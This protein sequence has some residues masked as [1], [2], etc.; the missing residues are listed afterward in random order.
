MLRRLALATSLVLGALAPTATAGPLDHHRCG[1]PAL[2]RQGPIPPLATHIPARAA[3]GGPKLTREG[4]GGSFQQH[5]STNFAIKWADPTV[6]IAQAQVV[7]D[8]LE[9]AWAKYV[10][11]LGHDPCTGC[12]TFR[13]NAYISRPDDYPG[14]DFGGGYAYIDDDGYP[15]FVISRSLFGGPETLEAIRGVAVHEFYHDIQF[16]TGA[17]QWGVTDYGW[18]WEA[19]AEWATQEALPTSANPYAFSGPFALKSELPLYHYGDPFGA[20]P[21]EG[22]HQ[23]GASIFFRYLTDKL[24]APGVIINTWEQASATDEPLAAVAAQLPSSDLVTIH[25]E[26]AARNA[27]WDYPYRQFI[28]E[29]IALYRGAYPGLSEIAGF[30]PPQGI[31][32]TALERSPYG[33]GYAT[34]ELRRPPTGRFRIDLQMATPSRPTE[35]HGTVVYGEPGAA[36]YTPLAITGTTGTVTMDVPETAVRLYLVVSATTDERLTGQPVPV[37]Y[38]VTPVEPEPEPE[39]ADAGGC[40][41]TGSK[42]TGSVIALAGVVLLALRRRRR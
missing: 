18:F 37:S 4:F 27:I 1:T 23:Y 8:A 36:T 5:L 6:T 21:V 32:M 35:L 31:G 17:F 28:I 38:Q 30:V 29:S 12:E 24:Q 20:D 25:T 15:Y 22:V 7:A 16:S 2:L 42:P 33:F 10:D 3:G 11:E 19:T 14:I 34:I 41:Q 13:L 26:F 39:P 40:C 9:L